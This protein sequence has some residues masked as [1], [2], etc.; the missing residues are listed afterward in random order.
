MSYLSVSSAQFGFSSP[1]ESSWTPISP[2]LL[3]LRS[4]FFSFED[5]LLRIHASA[6]QLLSVSPQLLSLKGKTA[7]SDYKLNEKD[8]SAVCILVFFFQKLGFHL[9][10]S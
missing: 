1:L 6:V 9:T 3:S 4:T 5:G 7:T 2:I 10:H 8:T